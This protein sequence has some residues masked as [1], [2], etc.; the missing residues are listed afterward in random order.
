M[1]TIYARLRHLAVLGDRRGS[2]AI[3]VGIMMVAIIGFAGL[4]IDV[5][6]LLLK[7]RQMQSAADGAAMTGATALSLGY[8]TDFRMEARAIA[9]AS[10]FTTGVDGSTVTVNSP[11]LQGPNAGNAAAVEVLVSQPQTAYLIGVFSPSGV[12]PVGARAVAIAQPG[13]TYCMLALDPTASGAAQIKNNAVVSNPECGVAVNSNNPSALIVNNNAAIDGP[14]HVHGGWSLSTNAALNGRPA[15]QYSSIIDDPYAGVT[16]PAAPACTSQSGTVGNG[17]TK[18]FNPGHFCSGFTIG[19]TAT[20]ILN[21]GAYYI[22]TKFNIGNNVTITGTGGVTLIVN[23]NYSLTFSNGARVTLVA[24]TTG[25][26]AGFA[27]FGL[28][29]ATASVTHTFSNNAT[30]D[31]QGVVYFPNQIV[32]FN[33]NGT[34]GISQCT[35]VVA[36]MISVSNNVLLN[37]NCDATGVQPIGSTLSQLSE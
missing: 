14:V 35:Q 6:Y 3:Q 18:T 9:S 33:N 30:M 28:R 25:P 2:V 29:T 23:G 5:S 15:A 10:G 27:I 12:I 21:P 36:R 7:H 8:P 31:I 24:P 37:N 26:Y 17:A 32:Q 13:Y 1:K 11:P 20:I 22:D 34:T 4:G 19:N 16:L